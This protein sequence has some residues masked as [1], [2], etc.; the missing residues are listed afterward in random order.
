MTVKRTKLYRD[1]SQGLL[2]RAFEFLDDMWNTTEFI[3]CPIPR[4]IKK[5][6]KIHTPTQA[7]YVI[8]AWQEQR[9]G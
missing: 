6:H 4:M 7:L 2:R 8:M 3:P 9:R 1:F 5:F